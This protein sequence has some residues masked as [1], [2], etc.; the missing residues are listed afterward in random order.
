MQILN[1]TDLDAVQG[2][3][4]SVG[5]TLLGI[6]GQKIVEVVID[7]VAL[8]SGVESTGGQMNDDARSN[9]YN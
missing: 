5:W 7:S 4:R 1:E 3:L 8:E 6:V 2:G 9:M